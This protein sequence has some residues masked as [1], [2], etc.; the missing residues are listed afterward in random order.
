LKEDWKKN[1]QI[2][3]AAVMLARMSGDRSRDLEP[4]DRQRVIAKAYGVLRL[5]GIFTKRVTYVVD[6]DRRIA[7]VFHHELSARKHLDDLEA[8]LASRGAA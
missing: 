3:F 1:Q 2:A 4:D 5:F 6:R 7:G 8:L